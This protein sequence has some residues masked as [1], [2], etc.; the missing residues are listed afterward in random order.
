[1]EVETMKSD[2]VMSWKQV[3]IPDVLYFQEG[4][5]VRNTQFTNSG[6][7]LLNV[8]NINFGDLNLD[9]TKVYIS[10]QEAYGKYNH[11]LVKE[12]DLLIA[13]SGI[14]VDN[15]HNK[16]TWAKKEH[17][18]LCLNTS[19]IRFRSLDET[20]LDIKYFSY[21]LKTR[22][23]ANQL[24]RLITGS[25]QLNFGPSHLKQISLPLPPIATQKRIAE[26]LDTADALR[27]KDQKLLKKYD[28]LAQAIFIDMFGDIMV[29]DHKFDIVKFGNVCEELFLG[30]TSKVDYVN[31]GG[32]PLIRATDIN[33]GILSF[34]NVKCISE[35]QHKKVTARRITKRGDVL[36]SKSGSL[37][38]CAIVDSDNEFSTYESIFTVRTNSK[39]FNNIFLVSLIRNPSFQEKL[40]G[41]KVGAGVAHLNLS[42]LRD[43]EFPLPPIDLQEK[44]AAISMNIEKQIDATNENNTSSKNIFNTLIQKAFEGE[45][46]AE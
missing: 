30:L 46:V 5:G 38:T 6:V 26:I 3:K 24:S 14:L 20:V 40:I 4:P 32:F 8:G 39:V 10:E 17:L 28:E 35:E 43:F 25:A 23:F 42:M 13:S 36:I 11:F 31:E 33:K 29:N 2:V 15:F 44:Y 12:G 1:M 22:L 19:T 37:G 45:L 34:D 9:A 7:K 18:P 41:G 27:R 16:I 21:F